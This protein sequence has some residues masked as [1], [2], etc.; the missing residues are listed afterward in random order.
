MAST[1]IAPAQAPNRTLIGPLSTQA[2]FQ[3]WYLVCLPDSIIAVRQ[4]ITAFFMF[5][6]SN[7]AAAPIHGLLGALI[8]Q[9]IGGQAR[10]FRERTE[11]NLQRTAISWLR[12]K[13]NAVYPVSQLKSIA[14]KNSKAGGN[15]ILPDIVLHSMNGAQ[16]KYGVQRPD[17]DKACLQLKQLYPH[18]CQ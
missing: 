18:L 17:F 3:Y 12:A 8:H 15:L 14:F 2:G 16:Q 1:G 6:L 9:L 13:P 5:G 11:T 4:S 7:G 10:A